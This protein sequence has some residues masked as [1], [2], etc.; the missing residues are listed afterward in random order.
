MDLGAERPGDRID[1]DKDKRLHALGKVVAETLNVQAAALEVLEHADWAFAAVYYDSID[2][3][4]HAFM[5]YHPP[6]QAR[7]PE[8]DYE[9]YCQIKDRRDRDRLSIAQI[10]RE[11]H[12]NART[13]GRWLAADRF[14]Q[15]QTPAR[16]SKSRRRIW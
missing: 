10:A 1:Q 6:R 15:R 5:D 3:F 7:V 11:L 8:R 14:R 16:S 2:H 9:L 12:L 13:V 4:S